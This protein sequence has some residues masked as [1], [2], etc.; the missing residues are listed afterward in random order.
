MLRAWTTHPAQIPFQCSWV[1]P[2]QVCSQQVPWET[3]KHSAVSIHLQYP[4]KQEKML[5]PTNL[6]PATHVRQ[7]PTSKREATLRM[8]VN[9]MQAIEAQVMKEFRSQMRM[10]RQPRD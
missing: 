3:L 4:E 10:A 2:E 8:G 5:S 1:V 7:G 6:C 9:S